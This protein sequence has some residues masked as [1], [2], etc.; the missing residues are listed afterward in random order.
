MNSVRSADEF[1]T[2]AKGHWRNPH[3]PKSAAFV[4]AR[5]G[6]HA[7]AVAIIDALLPTLNLASPWQKG[8]FD[9]ATNLR[10]MLL[11]DPAEVH[12]QLAAWE[13]YTIGKLKLEA[14]R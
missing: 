7:R 4:L 9:D 8:I 3:T 12:R 13:D 10:C 2:M 6:Q 11:E 1:V 5:D 14:F